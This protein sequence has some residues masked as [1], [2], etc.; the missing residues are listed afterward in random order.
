MGKTDVKTVWQIC[1]TLMASCPTLIDDIMN[2][3]EPDEL[4]RLINH[5]A[6]LME[7]EGLKRSKEILGDLLEIYIKNHLFSIG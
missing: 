2:T 5:A 3:Q 4:N 6:A 7:A 1:D